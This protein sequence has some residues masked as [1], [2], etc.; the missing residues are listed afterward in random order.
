MVTPGPG[1]T[2]LK[3]ARQGLGLRS[4][5]AL[6]D[7]VTRIARSIGLRIS[8]TARTGATVGVR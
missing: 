2:R 8:V 4:Q 7:A 3:G 1:N 5:Q 6:A